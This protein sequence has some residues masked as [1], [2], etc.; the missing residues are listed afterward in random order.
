[1]KADRPARRLRGLHS[2][3]RQPDSRKFFE[4]TKKTGS[5]GK[6]YSNRDQHLEKK[7][8]GEGQVQS[9][10]FEAEPECEC[11]HQPV[12]DGPCE[13]C[14]KTPGAFQD[15]Q[16]AAETN[17]RA[18][19]A[20]LDR[21]RNPAR[22]NLERPHELS[23]E[24]SQHVK[25]DHEQHDDHH[26]ALRQMSQRL[27]RDAGA[28][29]ESRIEQRRHSESEQHDHVEQTVHGERCEGAGKGHGRFACDSVRP[30]DFAGSGRNE[31][32]HHRPDCQGSPQR[33][34]RKI[35]RNGL[36]NYSPSVSPQREYQC[37][38]D[39]RGDE[40]RQVGAGE[41]VP[42]CDKSETPR[43]V[44]TSS[45][46]LSAIPIALRQLI[47]KLQPSA[48]RP[49]RSRSS[50]IVSV[51]R[52]LTGVARSGSNLERAVESRPAAVEKRIDRNRWRRCG[53]LS[54][55]AGNTS[56][57]RDA[58]AEKIVQLASARGV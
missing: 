1:M 17:Q 11:V 43:S 9:H 46:M 21:G 8:G 42:D 22:E 27:S 50:S 54:C 44:H 31:V 28:S 6:R 19:S 49:M 56:E 23:G 7:R 57:L 48:A 5:R 52:C 40:K 14:E 24:E 25:R 32:V 20:L 16:A 33:A 34:Q 2:V 38:G 45:A 55:A 39:C 4:H 30:C 47:F 3:N 13:H 26:R 12:R 37:R 53:R 18:L 58:R 36:E 35:R 15:A 29:W 41:L 10:R 51:G